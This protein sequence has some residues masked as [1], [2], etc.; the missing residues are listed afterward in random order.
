MKKIIFNISVIIVGFCLISCSKNKILQE[1]L[2][3]NNAELLSIQ[4]NNTHNGYDVWY[5]CKTAGDAVALL[6]DYGCTDINDL[7]DWDYTPTDKFWFEL[8]S[9]YKETIDKPLTTGIY[10]ITDI[11]YND[12]K[13]HAY[14]CEIYIV[15]IVG[16]I[17]KKS[18]AMDSIADEYWSGYHSLNSNY[19]NGK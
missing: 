16:Q 9:S 15:D 4:E 7:L 2:Q 19:E 13:I 5:Y 6:K 3:N 8:S 10:I 14:E 12:K 1:K 17:E 11:T 18:N